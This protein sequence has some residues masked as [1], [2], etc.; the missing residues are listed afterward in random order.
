MARLPS[1]KSEKLRVLLAELEGGDAGPGS[2]NLWNS[3]Q[4]VVVSLEATRDGD[5]PDPAPGAVAEAEAIEKA[6]LRLAEFERSGKFRVQLGDDP[7]EAPGTRGGKGLRLLGTVASVVAFTA[8]TG[9]HG[10]IHAWVGMNQESDEEE[11]RALARR[12]RRIQTKVSEARERKAAAAI[13]AGIEGALP[14]AGGA[15][16]EV[17]A[18]FRAFAEDPYRAGSVEGA[19]TA[20]SAR[21][22]VLQREHLLLRARALLAAGGG[23]S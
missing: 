13:A 18:A 6:A 23:A 10:L 16:E 12:R 15:V 2:G 20:L 7:G 19:A 21:L 3:L 8:I 4:A 9:G 14:S 11:R 5:P 22:E 17:R 1:A